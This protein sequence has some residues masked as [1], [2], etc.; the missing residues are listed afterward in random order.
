M[1]MDKWFDATLC[2]VCD[3]LSMLG[4]KL[5]YVSERGHSCWH[6]LSIASMY[7][8]TLDLLSMQLMIH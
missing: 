6:E 3:Y 8:E 7:D 2:G 1:G 5:I 4:L